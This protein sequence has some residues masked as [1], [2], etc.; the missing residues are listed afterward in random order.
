MLKKLLQKLFPSLYPQ[1]ATGKYLD[2]KLEQLA[3]YVLLYQK[4]TSNPIE[5][6]HTYSLPV[7][8]S[9]DTHKIIGFKEGDDINAIE[10]FTEVADP[11]IL[12][13]DDKECMQ[14]LGDKRYVV[15]I[16]KAR[17]YTLEP[18]QPDKLDEKIEDFNKMSKGKAEPLKAEDLCN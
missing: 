15:P 10:K 17:E 11:F 2:K 9:N 13:H 3:K 1:E 7:F 4:Q 8:E 18:R 16:Y 6:S 12:K 5:I 14:Y